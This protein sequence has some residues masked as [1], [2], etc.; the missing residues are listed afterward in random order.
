MRFLVAALAL[1]VLPFGW[2]V[3]AAVSE[4]G[5]GRS[6]ATTGRAPA[7]PLFESASSCIACHNGLVTPAGEDVSIGTSWRGS[8]MANSARDPYWQAAVRREIME[9]PESRAAIE[10]E[11][12]ICHMPMGTF[13]ARADGKQGTIFTHLARL[14]GTGSATLATEGV[15]CTVCHQIAPDRFGERESFNGRFAIDTR[16]PLGARPLFGPILVDSG[17]VTLMH[18]A[19]GFRPTRAD[20][21]QQSELCATCHTLHTHALGPGG[22]V[23]GEFPEQTPYLE[24]RYSAYR[25]E[26]SCQS[27]HM[28]EVSERVAVASV[29]G[30]PRANVSRHE[31]RGGN[32]F[33]L[34]MLN[35]YRNELGVEALPQELEATERS[36]VHH[37]Q[38][39]TSSVVVH[40]VS[41][42]GGRLAADIAVGNKAG[43][44]L[45]SAYPSRRVWLELRVYDGGGNSVF[46]SGALA[47]DGR[48]VGNDNDEHP[49]RFEPHRDTIVARD[50]VQIYEAIMADRNG[51]VTT[52]LLSAVRYVKDNRL[53]PRGFEKAGAPADVAVHGAAS[54]DA[55]FRDG[56]DRVSYVVDVGNAAG[57]FRVEAVLWYQPIAFRWAQNLR[58]FDAPETRRFLSYYDAMASVSALPLARDSRQV[59]R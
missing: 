28:P 3:G 41:V 37:L 11:C 14:Q 33:M 59:G 2:L 58:A 38:T 30:V 26:R 56:S 51:V 40:R 22:A 57:P 20:H 48:I 47:P 10:D 52:G 24:W 17:R 7:A 31:F 35:R 8:L 32:F 36:T 5:Y 4:P 21:V 43:H 39:A 50:Q 44:K 29:L 34:R 1:A 13:Q 53:L 19:S 45:P 15:S 55:N 12:S 25:A 16:I 54:R 46:V 23:L 27:C 42:N 49:A 18:S 9:H 6:S